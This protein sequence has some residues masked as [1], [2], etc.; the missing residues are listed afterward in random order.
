MEGNKQIT[1]E[2]LYAEIR[3]IKEEVNKACKHLEML[4]GS[5]QSV[6]ATTLLNENKINNLKDWQR[7]GGYYTI[8]VSVLTGVIGFLGAVIYFLNK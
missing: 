8:V 6:K 4:N 3:F 2:V 5:V 1:N 7:I